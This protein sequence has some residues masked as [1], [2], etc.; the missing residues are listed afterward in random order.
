[1]GWREG[2]VCFIELRKNEIQPFCL[3]SERGLLSHFLL[4]SFGEN[5]AFA[6]GFRIYCMPYLL[7]S[8]HKTTLLII[9]KK[10]KKVINKY[11]NK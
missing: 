4:Y 3:V 10:Y 2:R 9:N 7:K 5:K 11:K 6:I 8:K 1:M